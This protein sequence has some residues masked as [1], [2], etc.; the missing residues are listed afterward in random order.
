MEKCCRGLTNWKVLV[1]MRGASVALGLSLGLMPIA[2]AQQT[3]VVYNGQ[4]EQSVRIINQAFEKAT[5]VKVIVH[6]D[7]SPPIV[8]QILAEGSHSPADVV[9]VENSTSINVLNEK[10][11]LAKVNASTLSQVPNQYNAPDGHW[12]GVVLRQNVLTW[13]PHL[14]TK[15]DLP[16]SMLGIAN[17]HWNGKVGVAP[18]DPDF[19]PL[20]NA[21]IALKGKAAALHWLEGLKK[22]AKIYDDDEGV[23]AAVQ[24]G[25]IAYGL[26]NN[27]YWA[28]ARQAIGAD[29]MVSKVAHFEPGDVGNLVNVSGA[30]VLKS[31][32]HPKLAQRYLA[33]MVSRDLQKK[34][35]E[36]NQ[37]FEYSVLP[38]VPANPVN[39]PFKDL[40]PPKVTTTQLGTYPEA[41]K[42]LEQVGLI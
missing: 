12:V 36:G 16:K 17:A 15:Q 5:G 21:V 23:V 34:L 40:H 28:R 24:R 42:L 30:G 33:F 32:P 39:T 14:I 8:K 26:T 22:Y 20:V 31:A 7:D 19:F 3:L 38:G 1:W 6:S 2:Q 9:Y 27:Y 4:H 18:S 41:V 13:N 29:K 10:G 37:D 35:A 25:E 11:K